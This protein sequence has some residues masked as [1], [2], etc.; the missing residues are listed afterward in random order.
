MPLELTVSSGFR[1]DDNQWYPATIDSIEETDH[2]QYGPGLKWII[3]LDDDADSEYPDTWAFSSQTISP[4]S[5]LYTWLTGIYGQA[6]TEGTVVDLGALIGMRVNVA[7]S[8]HPSDPTKQVIARF[9]DLDEATPEPTSPS[10]KQ[11]TD[12]VKRARPADI[13]TDLPF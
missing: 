13:K 8:A 1:R 4:G 2:A 7:F 6:P 11:F 9:G 3:I 10:A 5:K 12:T